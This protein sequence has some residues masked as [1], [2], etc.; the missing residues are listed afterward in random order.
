M[1]LA[2]SIL[3]VLM[4]V[5]YAVLLTVYAIDFYAEK[6]D[7]TRTTK[8]LLIST[9]AVHF[10]YILLRSVE[11]S[12]TP[13]TNKFEMFTSIAFTVTLAYFI[14]ENLTKVRI[15]G[16]LILI[17]AFFFQMFS[18]IFIGNVYEVKEVLRS[19][20]LGVHVISALLGISGLLISAV[21]G[22]LY[23]VLYDRIK[24]HNY[25][26]YFNKLPS[27]ESL[28]NMSFI[29]LVAGYVILSF[30]ILIGAIWLPIAFPE[31]THYDPKLLSTI[32]I[33][34]VYSIGIAAKFIFKWYGKKVI[35]F[36]IIGCIILIISMLIPFVFTS[37]FHNFR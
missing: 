17:I 4:P 18:S 20:L 2:I 21:Y 30:S 11:F 8:Y 13:I 7:L 23:V 26:T 28:G 35:Y 16:F 1:L 3:N 27:L 37:S 32:F 6:A 10:I 14:I 24:N 34:L 22:I 29:A 25:G 36:S 19:P 5:L 33:W 31:F 12:H 9:I 15:T